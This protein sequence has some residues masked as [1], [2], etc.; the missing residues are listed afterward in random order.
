MLDVSSGSLVFSAPA[1]TGQGRAV[2]FSPDGTELATAGGDGGSVWDARSGKR[3]ARLRGA[4][5]FGAIAFSP[6]GT[7]IATGGD[8]GTVRLWDPASGQTTLTLT[9]HTGAITGVGFSPDGTRIASTSFDGTLRVYVLSVERLEQIARARLTRT[10]T[11]AEC[12]QYLDVVPCP[13]S[14]RALPA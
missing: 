9:G 11:R 14:V 13:P 1:A 2:A 3:I 4:S 8:D 10:L 12:L 6:D 7:R 5:A